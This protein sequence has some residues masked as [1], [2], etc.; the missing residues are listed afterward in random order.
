MSNLANDKLLEEVEFY[1]DYF[2]GTIMEAMLTND[3]EMN[4]LEQ[5]RVHLKEARDTAWKREY[6]PTL[7]V[8]TF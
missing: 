7:E 6:H 5:L 1:R 4:D 3:L 2:S 8:D